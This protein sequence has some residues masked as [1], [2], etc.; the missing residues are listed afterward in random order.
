M[1]KWEQC[2]KERV[3]HGSVIDKY[4]VNPPIDERGREELNFARSSYNHIS[5]YMK[6][7]EFAMDKVW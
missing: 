7:L 2:L 5:G 1:D 6:G 3:E 4:T